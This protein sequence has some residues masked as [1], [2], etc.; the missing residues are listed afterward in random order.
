MSND[1][2]FRVHARLLHEGIGGIEMTAKQTPFVDILRLHAED[3]YSDYGHSKSARLLSQA[4]DEI[5]RLRSNSLALEDE[6]NGY[7]DGVGDV[8]RQDHAGETLWAAA[9]RVMSDRDRLRAELAS[10][11]EALGLLTRLHGSIQIDSSDPMGMA[12]QIE[13]HVRA[14]LAEAKRDSERYR[15][16]TYDHDDAEQRKRCREIWDCGCVMSYSALSVDIDAA[17]AGG[18]K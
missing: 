5:E 8:L 4:A 15:W 18:S 6:K 1:M 9:Q 7:M 2:R 17:M 13:E 16:L 10:W 3:L 11:Q 14:E 12:K